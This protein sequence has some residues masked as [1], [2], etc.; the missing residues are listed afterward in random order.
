MKHSFLALAVAILAPLATNAWFSVL[1]GSGIAFEL[2]TPGSISSALESDG[3]P[4]ALFAIVEQIP[5]SA[6]LVPA[7]IILIFL[8]LATSADSIAYTASMIVSG[9]AP[10]AEADAVLA[11]EGN[12]RGVNKAAVA[13]TNTR[14]LETMPM[15]RLVT[16]SPLTPRNHSETQTN[17]QR[18]P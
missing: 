17:D 14:R 8:F 10:E 7:F 2:G 16:R 6:L 4:A 13:E 11:K 12:T 1:G 18:R 5:A 15:A 9:S 3:L